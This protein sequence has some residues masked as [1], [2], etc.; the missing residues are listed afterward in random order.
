MLVEID[1]IEFW[2]KEKLKSVIFDLMTN[3]VE[4]RINTARYV[5]NIFTTVFEYKLYLK[6]NE[7]Q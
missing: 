7:K 1:N 6:K 4:S 2:K 3:E 5:Q